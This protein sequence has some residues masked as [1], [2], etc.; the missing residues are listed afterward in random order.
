VHEF[1]EPGDYDVLEER[2]ID[3][4]NNCQSGYEIL[5]IRLA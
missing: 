2:F 1:T 4:E 5:E 3:V